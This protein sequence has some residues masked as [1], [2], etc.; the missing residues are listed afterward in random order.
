MLLAH[1]AQLAKVRTLGTARSSFQLLSLLVRFVNLSVPIV[2]RETCTPKNCK[3]HRR[4]IARSS[5]KWL[6]SCCQP[7]PAG[8]M[9]LVLYRIK[10]VGTQNGAHV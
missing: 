6:K 3:E 5:T 8:S 1:Q 10:V 2:S 9:Y 4:D 7:I